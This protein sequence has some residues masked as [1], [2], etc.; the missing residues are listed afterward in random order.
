[1][2]Q[3]KGPEQALMERAKHL[4][5]AKGVLTLIRGNENW[6]YSLDGTSLIFRFTAD[7]HRSEKELEGELEWIQ[8]LSEK[9]CHVVTPVLSKH[10]KF[11][12]ALSDTWC[13]VVFQ[14][15]PGTPLTEESQFTERVFRDWGFCIGAFHKHTKLYKPA[16]IKRPHWDEDDGFR[17]SQMIIPVLGED[18][19]MVL[20]FK[21]LV[22]ELRALPKAPDTFGLIHADLHQGNFFVTERGE[23]V[24]FDFDDSIYCWFLYDLAIPMATMDLSFLRGRF[25]TNL[26]RYQD[27]FLEGYARQETMTGNVEQGLETFVRYRFAHTYLWAASRLH[28]QRTN[29]IDIIKELMSCC[30]TYFRKIR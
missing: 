16:V 25:Q 15:A 10:N 9:K 13:V 7:Y 1:M 4:W 18:H 30:Q 29:D 8:Y 2:S 12:H 14:T 24:A 27:V 17:L 26:R 21:N 19:E 5:N 23:F 22:Q 20:I 28:L 6:V 3:Y 11:V